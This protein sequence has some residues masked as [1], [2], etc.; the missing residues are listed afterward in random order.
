MT[1]AMLWSYLRTWI[2][3]DSID[4]I[5]GRALHQLN[6]IAALVEAADEETVLDAVKRRI[7]ECGG[8]R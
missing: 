8:P 3:T 1:A 7:S 6:E 4:T 5:S 2:R